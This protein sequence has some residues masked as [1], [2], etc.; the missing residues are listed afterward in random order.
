M[1]EQSYEISSPSPSLF[2]INLLEGY[3][4]EISSNDEFEHI[5]NEILDNTSNDNTSN[6]CSEDFEENQESDC[7]IFEQD[8]AIDNLKYTKFTPCIV[9]NFIK[10]E[11]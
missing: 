2:S 1:L 6:I 9:I 11:I 3:N 8:K 10:G 4:D 5:F 7:E